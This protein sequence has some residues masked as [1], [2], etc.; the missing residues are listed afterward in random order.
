MYI[1]NTVEWWKLRIY[2]DTTEFLKNPNV[3]NQAKLT[4]ALESYHAFV[5]KHRTHS[6]DSY[7]DY[8]QLISA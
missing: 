8:E 7:D 3:K 1:E 2:Q 4:V 5:A 6:N